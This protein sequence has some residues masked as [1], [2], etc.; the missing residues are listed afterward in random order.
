MKRLLAV[1]LIAAIT[2]L[3]SF[4]A[5][6]SEVATVRVWFAGTAEPMMRVVNEQLLPAFH[7]A[8][9]GI[10]IEV[11]FIPWN[12]LSP[13]LL[14]SFA[15]NVAPDLF[16]HGQA[17]TAGF[18]S[19][20]VLEPLDEYL[21]KSPG[22]LE[23]FGASLDA[24][25]YEGKRYMIPV[26][27]SGTLLAYRADFYEEVGL[28]PN[29]PPRTWEELRESALKLAR[30]RGNRFE[31]EGIS[32]RIA[33]AQQ[34]WSP[35]LWQNGGE[36]FSEDGKQVLFDSPEAIEALEFY[37]S[38]FDDAIADKRENQPIGNLPVLAAGAVAQE[39]TTVENLKTI[40]TYAPDVYPNVRVAPPLTRVQPA[41]WYSFAG[42]F[43]AKQSANKE[44]TWE[45]LQ[46]LT[47]PEALEALTY[48]L[49]GLPPRASLAGVPHVAEDPNVIDRK[50]VV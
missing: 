44:A 7:Q 10:R 15:G 40:A 32:V 5:G 30:K 18:A 16:M 43:M 9:P 41:A 13:K 45:V 31:R 39:F 47:S 14:T 38:L 50:S 12:E 17:A 26:Y 3:T 2:L 34:D 35:F 36:L 48:S 27:G 4:A 42:F 1:V 8:H 25:L 29:N 28:D 37:V 33:A 19:A 22:M 11:D 20:G 23:D 21:E 6:A 24:G 46:F 49:S